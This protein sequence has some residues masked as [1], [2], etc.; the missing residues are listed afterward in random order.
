MVHW[1]QWT[2]EMSN[3]HIN[4]HWTFA[5]QGIHTCPSI[6]YITTRTKKSQREPHLYSADHAVILGLANTLLATAEH[7]RLSSIKQN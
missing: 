6:E 1:I 2:F 7:H 4:V 3:G 5:D